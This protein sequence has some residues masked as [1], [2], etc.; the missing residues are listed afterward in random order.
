MIDY[1]DRLY[2]SW[3]IHDFIQEH[4]PPYTISFPF[5]DHNDV[6]ILDVHGDRV[7]ST[8]QGICEKDLEAIAVALN[9]ATKKNEGDK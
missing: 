8:K 5:G 9:I 1:T 4:E 2:A 6:A 7:I 3:A